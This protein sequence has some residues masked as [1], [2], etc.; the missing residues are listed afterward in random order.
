MFMT[1]WF[2]EKSAGITVLCF[3]LFFYWSENTGTIKTVEV[4]KID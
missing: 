1:F 4:M 2:K 3:R